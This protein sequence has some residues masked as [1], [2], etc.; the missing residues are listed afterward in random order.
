VAK[1][2]IEVGIA[3]ET[4]AFAQGVEAGIIKPVEE[5]DKALQDLGRNA[6]PEQLERSIDDAA[7]ATQRLEQEVD[8]TADAIERE[9]R[10]AYASQRRSADQTASHGRATMQELKQ[11]GIQNLSETFSSF[12]GSISS[13][14]G[15]LQGTFGGV[16]AG[17]AQINPAL[18]PV[19][20]GA[21]AAIGLIAAGITG[22]EQD[23]EA[24]RAKVAELT[25]EFIESGT[26]G[27]R[28]FSGMADEVRKLV[29]E[30]DQ[31]KASLDRLDGL[32]KSLGDSF[33]DVVAAYTR[34]GDP[35]DDLIDKTE[36]LAA[37][38][39][40]R[41]LE[42]Q[43]FN[44]WQSQEASNRAA[45]L[46]HELGLLRDQRD[47]IAK[48]VEQQELYF[49]SGVSEL[50]AKAGLIEAINTAY[51]EA[52][53]STQAFIDAESGV[54]DTAAYIQS[55][56]ERE[57][58][59]RNYQTTLAT[60][61]LSN[62]AKSFLNEQGAEAAAAMLAGYQSADAATR[63][64]LDRIW[65]EAGEQNSGTYTAKLRAGF[66][67]VTVPGQTVVPATPTGDEIIR[68]LTRSL[69]G[70]S[71]EITGTIR[72]PYGVIAK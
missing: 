71:V 67:G 4:K 47:A 33:E 11:E 48:A 31:S 34:G 41:A 2:P 61:G 16:I 20:A 46:E 30:T 69:V 3:S 55:M 32:A 57:S 8:E 13:F 50:E 19:A 45:D 21:A 28:T 1:P 44:E 23:T 51:D 39:R 26:I 37:E 14:A 63:A 17:L 66:A 53:G 52:A 10:T 62:E 59:L 58:A 65:S 15:G 49:S 12:D 38:E 35:L 27:G 40:I 68:D 25:A 29:T 70:R 42:L 64:E 56:Q 72:T 54:F 5:A 7:R 36:A 60:S 43:G 18:I 6:G 22:A 9:F 24:F